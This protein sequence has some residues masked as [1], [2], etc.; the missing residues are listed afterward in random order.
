[1]GPDLQFAQVS[2]LQPF[3]LARLHSNNV[4]GVLS[5]SLFAPQFSSL[6]AIEKKLKKEM[7]DE[8]TSDGGNP[9]KILPML[10]TILAK[11]NNV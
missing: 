7:A 9:A 11:T 5:L 1:L 2:L 6:I 8:T 3:S 4:R 10:F